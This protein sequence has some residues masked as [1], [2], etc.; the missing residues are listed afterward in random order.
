MLI[1]N[2]Q[3]PKTQTPNTAKEGKRKREHRCI[4]RSF[5]NKK[6]TLYE[7]PYFL[8]IHQINFIRSSFNV[9]VLFLEIFRFLYKLWIQMKTDY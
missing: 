4:Q 8:N 5:S 2:S 6:Q 7:N 9:N 1:R 3:T